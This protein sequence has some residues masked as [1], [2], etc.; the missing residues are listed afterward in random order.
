MSSIDLDSP[1]EKPLISPD[2]VGEEIAWEKSL[3][4][5][6]LSE[7]IGQTAIKE[8]LNVFLQASQQRNTPLDHILLYGPPGLGKTTLAHIIA[9]EQGSSIKTTSGPAI[10]KAGDLAG[11]LTSLEDGDILF[12]DEIHRL[13][14]IVEEILYPA[15][16]DFHLDLMVGKGP[17]ARSIQ[18]QLKHFTLIGATTRASL[19][20]SPLRDRF[21][22]VF[23]LN[24]YEPGEIEIILERSSSLLNI[25]LHKE[26][27]TIIA[28]R[29]RRTP[30]IA[31]R[32]LRRLR[33]FAQVKGEGIIDENIVEIGMNHLGIDALGLDVIDRQILEAIANKFSGGPVGI[34]TLSASSGEDRDTIE[35]MYEPFW[36]QMGLIDRTPRGRILTQRGY[37][38]LGL[39]SSPDNQLF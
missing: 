5:L 34:D 12:I 28:Q 13:P 8:S 24:F 6:N 9:S 14:R 38:H 4:P 37:A 36:L 23:H 11:L 21:G 29:S 17:G 19:I 27:N 26:A 32:L 22:A 30:R 1:Y 25:P 7:Y 2:A 18:L 3:R 33:D 15:M 16:E 39:A 10:V 31:N 20:S 35:E